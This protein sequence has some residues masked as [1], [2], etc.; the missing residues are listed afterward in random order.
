MIIQ[1]AGQTLTYW[2]FGELPKPQKVVTALHDYW[3]IWV[4]APITAC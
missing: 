1:D 4:E 3:L 2:C